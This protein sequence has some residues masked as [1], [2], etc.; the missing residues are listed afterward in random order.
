[1]KRLIFVFVTVMMLAVTATPALACGSHH[2]GTGAASYS[3]C[4]TKSCTL[5]GLH[6]HNGK[7]Y[8]AHYY[9]D[10]HDYHGYCDIAS[11]TLTGYHEHD[12]AYCFGH[13][14]NDGHSYH[15]RNTG[16]H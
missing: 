5:T 11:C 15:N 13:T 2:S 12:G 7:Y 6:A 8:Y 14:A 9:G 10:G 3:V 1:M 16:H 4:T